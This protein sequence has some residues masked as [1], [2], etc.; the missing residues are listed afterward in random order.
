M[1]RNLPLASVYSGIAS[2]YK[3]HEKLLLRPYSAASSSSMDST[4]RSFLQQAK[5]LEGLAGKARRKIS[6]E[7]IFEFDAD[8]SHSQSR[9]SRGALLFVKGHDFFLINFFSLC[10][11]NFLDEET[12]PSFRNRI[13]SRGPSFGISER[14][15]TRL[16]QLANSA[17]EA[18]EKPPSFE[19]GEV[20]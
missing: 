18:I 6:K 8:I 7:R 19:I 10:Q 11:L 3:K 4:L 15:G 16:L 12:C 14:I 5:T 20:I 1:G 13:N 9:C 17:A 2:N